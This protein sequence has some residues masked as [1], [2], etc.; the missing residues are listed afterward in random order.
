MI[1]ILTSAQMRALEKAAIASGSA[2]G[3]RLMEAAGQGVVDAIFQEWPEFAHAFHKAV[4]LCGPGHNGG[5]GFV[6]ARL[7]R[8]RGWDVDCF[9]YG[10]PDKLPADA[11]INYER[12][13]E[14][15]KVALLTEASLDG[16]AKE[17]PETV[18]AVDAILGT[19]LTR[20]FTSLERVCRALNSWHAGAKQNLPKVVSVDIP[21]G[22]CA[23]SGVYL[24]HEGN[25]FD[26]CIMA[27]LTVSF[28][29]MKLGHVLAQ[30]PIGAQKTVVVDIGLGGVPRP[31]LECVPPPS[32]SGGAGSADFCDVVT[33]GGRH[34]FDLAKRAQSHKF[35]HGHAF[36]VSGPSGQ[37]GAARIAA[38]GAL[39]IGAGVVTVGAPK[40]A[41]SEC[42]AQ[43]TAIML[44]EVDDRQA[45]NL[46]LKD[47]RINALCI[48]P[49]LG[50]NTRA[51]EL[52][53]AAL[54]NGRKTV[55]DADALTLLSQDKA[56]FDKL[57]KDCVLT[58]HTGEFR[59][60][61]PDIA[62][63]IDALTTTGPAYSK[64][65]AVR[66]AAKRAGCTV[67]LK[68][69]DT[70]IASPGG[71]TSINASLYERSA[72]WLATAGSGDVLAGFITGLMARGF[73]VHSAA[74]IGAY[75]HTECALSFGAGLIAEDL[76]DEIPNVFKALG[77]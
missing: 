45:L 25:S 2:S 18:L 69:P 30:G 37:T 70:V 54:E 76:P 35:S 53:S 15:G 21:S 32:A 57:H 61:F 3:L 23:D 5:D 39:R 13:R 49:A 66:D 31:W 34:A 12:W 75:L 65:D 71:R 7:L 17:N 55:L 10:D 48:G 50:K 56:L 52:I 33:L 59:R 40:S 8:Q 72:P 1:E 47:D 27:N 46:I 73:S 42:A 36:I 63:K 74:E 28:H 62:A 41:I 44:T 67:L 60:L 77:I 64:V 9:L 22:L 38:R 11:R 6:I 14:V 19:G 43:L 51:V 58:P 20:P 26:Q 29:S 68:G 16:Y 24:G 4:V